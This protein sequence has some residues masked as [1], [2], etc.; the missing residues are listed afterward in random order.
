MKVK[1]SWAPFAMIALW[2]SIVLTLYLAPSPA[3]YYAGDLMA[4]SL[5]L[6]CFI[7]IGIRRS[8]SIKALIQLTPLLGLLIFVLATDVFYERV[9]SIDF[10]KNTVVGF[11]A[12]MSLHFVFRHLQSLRARL[13]VCAI[14]L[15]P[16]LIHLV[17]MYVDIAKSILEAGPVLPPVESGWSELGEKLAKK[18]PEGLPPQNSAG[19][20]ETVKEAPR[21]GRRY[22]S[23]A[24]VHLLWG[25]ALL[26]LFFRRGSVRY[27][28]WSLV[29]I[30]SL[31]L[32]LLDARAAYASVL[33]GSLIMACVVGWNRLGDFVKPV[34][35][36]TPWRV[37]VLAGLV[38][39]FVAIGFS[40]GKSRW[41]SSSYSLQAAVHD[42]YESKQ[43]LGLRPYAN[44]EFWSTPIDE[45]DAE[46]L[47]FRL[48]VD[49]SAYLRLAWLLVGLQ[50][51]VD[52][53]LGMGYSDE[54][55][56]HLFGGGEDKY[57][58]TDSF[59]VEC[60][61]SFGIVGVFF[62]TI[63]W[64]RVAYTLQR[65]LREG[66]I[67]SGLLAA[68]GGLIFVC[69]GRGM[70]DVFTDGL[71]RYLMALLGMYYGLL[72]AGEQRVRE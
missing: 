35:Q 20:L 1:R 39:L 2:L 11:L 8:G 51:V 65:A 14:F 49:Q 72:H 59:L 25:G 50:N 53:P 37:I 47:E 42:V 5:L 44:K 46:V 24:M 32:A 58:R 9:S 30:G 61:L 69:V 19:F 55:L 71:W 13:L 18:M 26:A 54:N 22:A 16:G 38:G 36:G 29:A 60:L 12:F 34:F 27:L 63:L 41:M 7:G 15:L 31:S 17:Y 67:S 21:V 43:V 45:L 4:G 40:A 10:I 28:G 66:H 48:R 52:Y 70:V 56:G 68:V 33:I 62:Y 6:V 3:K 23:M 57:Q 64:G